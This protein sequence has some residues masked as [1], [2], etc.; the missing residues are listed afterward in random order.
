MPPCT[1]GPFSDPPINQPFLTV[2]ICNSVFHCAVHNVSILEKII[3][4]PKPA[5]FPFCPTPSLHNHILG[6]DYNDKLNFFLWHLFRVRY[7][8]FLKNDTDLMISYFPSTFLQLRF[9]S[10]LVFLL[11]QKAKYN[12]QVFI[13]EAWSADSCE[14]LSYEHLRSATHQPQNG[15]SPFSFSAS[16]WLLPCSHSHA[17]WPHWLLPARLVSF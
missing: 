17:H 14:L 15:T 8:R 5:N 16:L 12:Q 10:F 1:T 2:T 13:K 3:Q 9:K 6:N 7:M 4:K 11:T